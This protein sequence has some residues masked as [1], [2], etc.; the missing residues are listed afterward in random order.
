[1]LFRSTG[2]FFKWGHQTQV[3]A[4][5]SP[6]HI[7]KEF[8][9][10]S[11]FVDEQK[12]TFRPLDLTS[13]IYDPGKV[14]LSDS[15]F[16]RL[17]PLVEFKLEDEDIKSHN[18]EKIIHAINQYAEVVRIA[19][20]RAILNAK[21]F[22]VV[23]LKST[24]N[25]NNLNEEQKK[26]FSKEQIKVLGVEQKKA[27]VQLGKASEV[28]IQN[29]VLSIQR[30]KEESIE[31][32]KTFMAGQQKK[33]L[34]LSAAKERI[35]RLLSISADVAI[36]DAVGFIYITK[37][38]LIHAYSEKIKPKVP[39]KIE[40]IALDTAAAPELE[41]I[42]QGGSDLKP[43]K[44]PPEI[45]KQIKKDAYIDKQADAD[46]G[47]YTKEEQ[48]ALGL[49]PEKPETMKQIK[50]NQDYIAKQANADVGWYT[51]REQKALSAGRMR[52]L[53]EE[54]GNIQFR[55][56]MWRDMFEN[57]CQKPFPLY[58]IGGMNFGKPQRSVS[59]EILL[60]GYTDWMRDGWIS[61]HNSYLNLIYR[62]GILGFAI[63]VG[64]WIILVR[65]GSLFF[66]TRSAVGILLASV[67]VYWM[68]IASFLVFL[69]I[70]Y[71]AV[72][73]W[74]FL[75]MVIAYSRGVSVKESK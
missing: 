67:L 46:V 26:S 42:P 61:P 5:S 13:N 31:K 16:L 48:G 14:S 28:A 4:F 41:V 23:A 34:A 53:N 73:F 8:R 22:Q 2:I 50:E 33:P 20:V 72:P 25:V 66:R 7:I 29:A 21:E 62:G 10:T 58:M 36:E 30:Q 49:N 24:I 40:E 32:I 1:M 12:K 27:L 74:L 70:P 15:A 75:G 56:L 47:W 65:L 19:V 69:E 59:L 37:D 68:V 44:K 57:L 6:L 71:Y 54:Y 45:M 9:E 64:L 35:R 11:V 39:E 43:T 51:K 60:Y 52:P 18:T 17:N 3:K 55:L 63:V 38:S